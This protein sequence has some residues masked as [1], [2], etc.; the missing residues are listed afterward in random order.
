LQV[1]AGVVSGQS[2]LL[3][4]VRDH[5]ILGVHAERV[6]HP[7]DVVEKAGDMGYVENRLIRKS[8]LLQGLNILLTHV[9]GPAGDAF[10]EFQ[11]LPGGGVDGR[12]PVVLFYRFDERVV[13]GFGTQILCVRLQS[14]KT[15]VGA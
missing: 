10:G 9:G 3:S 15:V 12:L 1:V 14:V 6:R 11:H 8:N 2:V 5:K 7:V 13:V 4:L